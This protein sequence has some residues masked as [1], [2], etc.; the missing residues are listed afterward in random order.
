MPPGTCAELINGVVYTPSPVGHTHG[1]A[2]SSTIVWLDRYEEATPGVEVLSGATTILGW[3]SEPEP[4]AL[5]RILPECGGQTR[6]EPT[7]IRNAP[8]LS[9]VEVSKA[10]RDNID[11][12]PKLDDYERGG[13]QEY[14]VRALDPDDLIWHVLQEGRLIAVSPGADGF[15]RSARFPGLWLDPAV[16]LAGNRAAVRAVLDQGRLHPS[17]PPSSPSWRPTGARPDQEG[18]RKRRTTPSNPYRDNLE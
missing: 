9:V 13:V 18:Q 2:Q 8:E 7:Y 12:G 17:M 6:D 15:Y 16:L 14:V 11:L 5:L 1:K 10:T 3:K 4:D